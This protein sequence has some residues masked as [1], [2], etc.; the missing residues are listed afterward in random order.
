MYNL[1][2]CHFRERGFNTFAF[3]PHCGESGAATHL[4]CGFMLAENIS[5]G[6]LLR[7]VMSYSSNNNYHRHRNRKYVVLFKISFAV[8]S[9]LFDS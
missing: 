8:F 9:I 1:D 5:H 4:V 6:L 7:K 3:R 2:L